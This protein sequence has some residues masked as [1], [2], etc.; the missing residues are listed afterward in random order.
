MSEPMYI[1]NGVS[2]ATVVDLKRNGKFPERPPR[3]RPGTKSYLVRVRPEP[4][5]DWRPTFRTI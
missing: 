1:E 3:P 4:P 5:P 2:S